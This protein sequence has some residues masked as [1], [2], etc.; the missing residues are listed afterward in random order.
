MIESAMVKASCSIKSS[1]R[2]PLSGC[3]NRQQ[4]GQMSVKPELNE[5]MRAMYVSVCRCNRTP[6]CQGLQ[7]RP[8]AQGW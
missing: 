7:N 4:F 3:A 8:H 5:F 2:S 1:G 6:A